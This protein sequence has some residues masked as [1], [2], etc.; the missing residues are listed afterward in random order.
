MGDNITLTITEHDAE[1]L[2]SFLEEHEPDEKDEAYDSLENIY[3][4]LYEAL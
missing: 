1:V 3:D 4:S 2:M